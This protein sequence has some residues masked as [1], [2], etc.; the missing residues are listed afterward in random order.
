MNYGGACF[1][2]RNDR[3]FAP[4]VSLVPASCSKGEEQRE[5]CG[6]EDDDYGG[7]LTLEHGQQLV[8]KA[9][10]DRMVFQRMHHPV[11]MEPCGIAEV[12]VAGCLPELSESLYCSGFVLTLESD[13]GTEM[14]PHSRLS[15]LVLTPPILTVTCPLP[16]LQP[17]SPSPRHLPTLLTICLL[18]E[19]CF[20]CCCVQFN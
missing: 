1:L 20:L 19:C 9:P 7:C 11:N 14:C 13:M 15:Y 5:M 10:L 18:K 8:K 17:S 6:T 12:L 4:N 3:C 16:C 2:C